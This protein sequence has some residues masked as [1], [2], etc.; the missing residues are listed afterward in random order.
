MEV[1]IWSDVVCPWC[2]IGKRR[3]ESALAQFDHADQVKLTWRSFELDPQAAPET[4]GD[5]AE[6]IAEKYNV[7]V[8][9][10][11][12]ME[13]HVTD[14]AAQD[15]LDYHFDI[16]RSANS[17]DSHRIIHL[18]GEHG[19]GDQ[20]KERLLRAYFTEGRL[21]SDHPTLVELAAEVGIDPEEARATLASDRFTDAVRE[22]EVTAQRFGLTGVPTFVVDRAVAV[23]GAQPPEVLLQLL[24]EAWDQR[25]P[26]V[27]ATGGESCGVDGC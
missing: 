6:R 20:M 1:E 21:I 22:D 10:A 8:E 18:A 27:V 12:S 14:T 9:Q 15:G 11:R 26:K 16:A 5:R 7:P 2:Y 24:D 25:S 3:F 13:Q 19:L 17:F 4:I 23:S